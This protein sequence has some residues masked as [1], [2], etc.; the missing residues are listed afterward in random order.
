MSY[1]TPA[2]A[3]GTRYFLV[4]ATDYPPPPTVTKF[5]TAL[6]AARHRLKHAMFRAS[7]WANA[8]AHEQLVME[9]CFN[10][11]PQQPAELANTLMRIHEVLQDTL[12]GLIGKDLNICEADPAKMPDRHA[13]G[14]VTMLGPF[15]GDIHVLF[16]PAATELPR[17]LIHEAT[18]KFSEPRTRATLRAPATF[19]IGSE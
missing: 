10:P 9:Y 8:T 19:S 16:A 5:T 3:E 14:Y 17:L 18:H 2:F 7:D 12:L 11:D 1:A 13:E 4:G 15:R 6:L